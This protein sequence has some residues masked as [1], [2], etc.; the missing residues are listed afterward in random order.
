MR[1]TR[2][3]G[4]N[5]TELM[6]VLAIVGVALGIA[7]PAFMSHVYNARSMEAK[8]ILESIAAA[9]ESYRFDHGEYFFDTQVFPEGYPGSERYIWWPPTPKYWNDSGF[10]LPSIGRYN[11]LYCKYAWRTGPNYKGYTS[12]A[13]CDINGNGKRAY[14]AYYVPDADG[15]IAD[16]PFGACNPDSLTLPP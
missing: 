7:I 14:Y 16:D 13:E 5:L 4:F 15:N 2:T 8:D 11:S 1:K 6:I 9:Q 10:F 3:H 12:G